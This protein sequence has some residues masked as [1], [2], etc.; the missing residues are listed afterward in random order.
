[1]E[2][3][4]DGVLIAL[5]LTALAEDMV[6]AKVRREDPSAPEAAVEA[7][8]IAW[9]QR[10]GSSHAELPDFVVVERSWS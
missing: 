4:R 9:R 7:A 5:E 8:V 1:M 2:V 3:P 6:R 10:T